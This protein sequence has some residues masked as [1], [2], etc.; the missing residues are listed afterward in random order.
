MV[1]FSVLWQKLK[2]FILLSEVKICSISLLIY[3]HFSK[4]I[5]I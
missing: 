5:E 4:F 1:N 3:L 2:T